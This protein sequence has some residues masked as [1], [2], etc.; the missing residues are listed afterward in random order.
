MS[1]SAFRVVH[2]LALRIVSSSYVVFSDKKRATGLATIVTLVDLSL[3]SAF[4]LESLTFRPLVFISAT[5]V[6]HI[7]PLDKKQKWKE[8]LATH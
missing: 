2:R 1:V 4:R 8:C 7:I 6:K 3:F 5:R